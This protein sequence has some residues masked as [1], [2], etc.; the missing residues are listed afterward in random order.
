V[1]LR[2]SLPTGRDRIF[3]VVL[4]VTPLVIGCAVAAASRHWL[5]LLAPP[6]GYLLAAAAWVALARRTRRLAYVS[7]SNL[8]PPPTNMVGRE[9]EVAQLI[10]YLQDGPVDGSAIA[11][12]HGV[13]GIGKT[14][15][16][17]YV[18]HL[19]AG[20][21]KGGELFARF[22][23]D[24]GREQ[25]VDTVRRRF[26]EALRLPGGRTP[27]D[28]DAA[29]QDA[30]YRRLIRK[31]SRRGRLLVVFDDVTEA[32]Q[33]R[34]LLP[35]TR[36]CA[37]IITSRR[38]IEGLAARPFPLGEL[39]EDD[40]KRMLAAIISQERVLAEEGAARQLVRAAA[41]H[42][43]A[44]QLV[45][46]ALAGR[47]HNLLSVALQ[48]M[49]ESPAPEKGTFDNAL[50]LSYA[51]LTREEQRALTALGLIDRRRFAPWELSALL[52]CGEPEAWQFCDR[53]TDAG[54]LERHSTDA[55]G[56]QFFRTLEHVARYVRRRAEARTGEGAALSLARL[57]VQRR[58]RREQ[59]PARADV[60]EHIQETVERGHLSTAF[61]EARD[62]IALARDQGD[63]STEAD[64]TAMLA[65]LHAQLGGLEDVLDLLAAP[66]FADHPVAR[67]RALRIRAKLHRRVRQLDQA[68]SR[69]AEARQLCAE[70]RDQREEVRL[71]RELAIVESLGETPA[72]G[73][74]YVAGARR[75]SAD[76][77]R[78]WA[79]L[80]YAE[81]R[82]LGGLG[83]YEEAQTVLAAGT[84][85]ADRHDQKLWATWL[86]YQQAYVALRQGRNEDVLVG[87]LR[88]LVDFNNMRHRYGGAHCRAL[89]GEALLAQGDSAGAMLFLGEALETFHNCGDDWVEAE[90]AECFAR[91]RLACGQTAEALGLF[92][93]AEVIYTAIGAKAHAARIQRERTLLGGTS[94]LLATLRTA[95]G[96]S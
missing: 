84:R 12:V 87:G 95:G 25:A 16:V 31:R 62:A 79:G 60:F 52:G 10:A 30:F 69:L 58:S 73:R 3:L 90:T 82:V 71:L 45:G 39:R 92:A 74:N 37:V 41:C 15:F 43:L 1:E 77:P 4:G 17:L 47:P 44:I 40:A 48:R 26:I 2:R 68:R 76:L 6:L 64:A 49:T 70:H 88:A 8:P 85:S 22:D 18:A 36:R 81:G 78:L 66:L 91:I 5:P 61:K 63:T 89:I 38:P 42:P 9:H 33:I 14:A 19:V 21:F 75:L 53:L 32:D 93:S 24:I 80:A 56:V 7:P 35:R 29:V 34:P 23:P 83:L 51:M 11:N 94:G 50:D 67:I 65:D 54:L 57:D 27:A 96:R 13:P 46:M 86:D 59:R 55:V 28:E 20:R 72:A